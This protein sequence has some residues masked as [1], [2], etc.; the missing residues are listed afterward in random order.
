[1]TVTNYKCLFFS[2]AT[3][4]A[5]CLVPVNWLRDK[6]G[7]QRFWKE[8]ISYEHQY[9]SRL[10]PQYPPRG[11]VSI[12]PRKDVKHYSL[13]FEVSRISIFTQVIFSTE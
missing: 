4:V 13:S 7:K 9:N 8:G 1:M 6:S 5:L 11:K 2:F 3:I 10:E 12:W